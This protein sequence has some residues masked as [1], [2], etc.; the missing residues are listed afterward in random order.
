MALLSLRTTLKPDIKASP[1]ELVFGEGL[2]V[3]GDL[4]PSFPGNND[5]LSRQRQSTLA[6]LRLEVERLQ[7]TQTSAHRIPNVHVPENLRNASHVMIRRGGV[8]P[9][10]TQPFQGPFRVESQTQTGVKVHVPGKGVEEIA[11]SRVKPA[12]A[13]NEDA[14]Q[15]V[16]D[17]DNEVPPSPPP[18][19]RRPGPRTRQP[20]PTTRKTCQQSKSRAV[21]PDPPPAPWC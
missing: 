10:L 9:P 21:G 1:A 18:P 4:L 13:E 15:E 19:G 14:E 16:D 8:S 12:F 6:N 7:P 5:E 11:L 2:A 3:P 17:L 20:E